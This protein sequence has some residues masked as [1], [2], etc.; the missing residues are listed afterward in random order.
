MLYQNVVDNWK[1]KK[2]YLEF[3]E[4]MAKN[5]ITEFENKLKRIVE[6]HMYKGN[7]TKKEAELLLSTMY[8]FD[9]PHFYIIWKILKI[10][11]L[12]RTIVARYAWLL[13]P[14]LI[15]VRHYLKKIIPNL[16]TF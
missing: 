15:F 8:T 10:P 13:T 11:I 12:G 14:A 9:I 16:K 6:S 7:C 1:T 5:I 2:T 3:K 4:E